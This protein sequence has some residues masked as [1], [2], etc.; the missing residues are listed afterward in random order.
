MY[1][2]GT[3]FVD[4]LLT[5]FSVGWQPQNLYG[6]SLMPIV[7][8]TSPSGQYRVFDR[9]NWI[10]HQD[11]R[12]PGTVAN[13][14]SG[15]KYS[16][17]TFTTKE[18]SLQAAVADEED[19]FLNS[20][21]GLADPAFGGALQLDPHED[22]VAAVKTSI[23]LR[24]EK[25]VADTVRNTANYPVGNTITLGAADQWDNYAGATSDPI[26]VL[27]N[28]VTK[29]Q[30]IIGKPPNRLMFPREGVPYI[31]NHPDVV[32]RFINFSLMDTEAWVKLIGLAPDS[33]II[34]VDSKYN[35]A[36]NIDATE[37]ITSL[38]GKDVGLFYV[39]DNPGLLTQTFGK[40]FAVPYPSGDVT[41]VDRWREEGR[42]S[43]IVRYSFRYDVK[44][45][46]GIAGYII[47]TAFSAT[48]W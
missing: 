14:I 33:Q 25:L 31:E 30:G 20:Q 18:H 26:I 5:N 9:S 2:P 21:G 16:F 43:D 28:A 3:L 8:T 11:R 36:D 42:K 4:P 17:D 40:T 39:E 10:L 48:A 44:I 19:Q 47:K 46:A 32:A 7:E 27:R 13:E 1:D 15:R 35:A 38:W 23:L 34:L 37:S 22:A 29:I 45:V 6:L 12:E 41:P 24:H